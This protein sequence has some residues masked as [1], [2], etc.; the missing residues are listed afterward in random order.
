MI[1]LRNTVLAMTM[2]LF[3]TGALA[4]SAQ[5]TQD[6]QS[7]TVAEELF[8]SGSVKLEFNPFLGVEDADFDAGDDM[9]VPKAKLILGGA[10]LAAGNRVPCD[11]D[12]SECNVRGAS[13]ELRL[14]VGHLGS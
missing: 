10:D 11:H 8:G 5:F 14:H 1:K 3:A 6:S 12:A 7:A 13:F 9:F 2:G 4:Q